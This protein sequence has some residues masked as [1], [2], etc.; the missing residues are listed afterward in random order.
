MVLLRKYSCSD[1]DMLMASRKIGESFTANLAQLAVARTDWNPEYAKDLLKRIDAGLEK[2]GVDSK[3]ELRSATSALDA[4]QSPAMKDLA[5]FKTSVD[6]DFKKD[7]SKKAEI[8]RTL[9]FT[10]HLRGVQKG[11]QDSL[12]E[13]MYTFTRNMTP[14]LKD[15]LTAKGMKVTLID[16]ISGY[17]DALKNAN[18]TQETFKSYTKEITLDVRVTFDAIYVEIIGICKKASKLFSDQPVKKDQFTFSKVVKQLG[19][20]PKKTQKAPLKEKV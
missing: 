4:I 5:F 14:A 19:G 2:L 3:K 11:N 6:D 18:V 13:L 12:I 17:A 16:K 15:D 1:V 7:T 8:F 20:T 9:G 10:E